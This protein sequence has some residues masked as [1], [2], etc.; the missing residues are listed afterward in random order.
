MIKRF[1]LIFLMA[2][3]LYAQV[4]VKEQPPASWFDEI[5]ALVM[6]KAPS[7]KNLIQMKMTPPPED[8]DNILK[9][10]DWISAG[11]Y[12]I[13]QKKISLY[14]RAV[15]LQY[16]FYRFNQ[17]G[18][19]LNF[20]VSSPSNGGPVVTHTNFDKTPFSSWNVRK[21]AGKYYLEDISYGE[22]TYISIVSYKDGVLVTDTSMT[23]KIGAKPYFRNV[24]IAVPPA[25]GWKFGE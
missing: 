12:H 14:Y 15:P 18:G 2:A 4:L 11:N 16:D 7:E 9:A 1:V 13:T 21:I 3:S 20:S 19:I 23:G 5:H 25:F 8:L 24:M 17:D 10:N 6:Q 22:K